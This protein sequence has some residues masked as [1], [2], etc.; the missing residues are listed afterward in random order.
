MLPGLEDRPACAWGVNKDKNNLA[1]EV[2]FAPSV[3]STERQIH[4]RV[5]AGLQDH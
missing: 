3:K 2:I 1:D 5:Y 4:V